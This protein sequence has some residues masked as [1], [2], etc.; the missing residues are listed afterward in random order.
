[1]KILHKLSPNIHPHDLINLYLIS[2]FHNF[3]V[4]KPNNNVSILFKIT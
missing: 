3:E 1:M 4:L 2:T